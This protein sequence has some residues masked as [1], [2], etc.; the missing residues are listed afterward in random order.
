LVQKLLGTRDTRKD[1]QRHDDDVISPCSQCRKQFRQV[2]HETCCHGNSVSRWQTIRHTKRPT[3]ATCNSI[4]FN[5]RR[6]DCISN[7]L[8]QKTK[9]ESKS[10]INVLSNFAC[11]C[12]QEL[13][14]TF[15]T[16]IS[17]VF[18]V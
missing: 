18:F 11:G 16:E 13:K 17:M 2:F 10:V 12:T 1:T 4:S 9:K 7:I 6:Y 14:D 15:I 3:H 8:F 5:R